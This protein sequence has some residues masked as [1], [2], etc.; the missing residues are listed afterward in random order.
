LGAARAAYQQAQA[1]YAAGLSNIYEFTQ[2]FTLLNRAEIDQFVTTNNV[3]RALLLKS[4][5]EGDLTDFIKLTT[6]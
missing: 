5:A 4:A 6:K 3:W 2:A 1:R